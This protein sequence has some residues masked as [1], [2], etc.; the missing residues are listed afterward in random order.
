MMI[1]ITINV[2]KKYICGLQLSKP[3]YFNVNNNNNNNN[4]N[5]KKKKK[6]K[7]WELESSK[8]EK[9]RQESDF[10]KNRRK[11]EGCMT[12]IQATGGC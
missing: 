6:K 4:N 8:E 10:Y 9:H 12:S 2:N 1:I 7:K 5:N 11:M 3:T